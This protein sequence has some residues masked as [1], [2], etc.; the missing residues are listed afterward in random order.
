MLRRSRRYHLP[1]DD[2]DDDDDAVLSPFCGRLRY[3]R[4][5]SYPVDDDDDDAV[6]SPFCGRLRYRR[7]LSYNLTLTVALVIS[8]TSLS[9]SSPVRNFE[10]RTTRDDSIL[11]G[12]FD[13]PEY[14]HQRWVFDMINVAPVWE[15]NIFGRGIRVVG[16]NAIDRWLLLF[17]IPA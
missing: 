13:D 12:F 4:R 9:R 7:R 2:D 1:V 5:L 14:E 15:Q 6:L 10:L 3:R 8:R 11:D 17:F 16:T